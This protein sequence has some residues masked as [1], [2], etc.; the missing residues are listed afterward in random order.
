M[1]EET[2]RASPVRVAAGAMALGRAAGT[3]AMAAAT[4]AAAAEVVVEMAG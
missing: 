4:R 3:L 1:A 2:V